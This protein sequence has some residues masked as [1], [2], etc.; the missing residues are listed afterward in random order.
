VKRPAGWYN[1]GWHRTNTGEGEFVQDEETTIAPSQPAQAT[2][3]PRLLLLLVA[4]TVIVGD[5]LSKLLVEQQL[6]LNA[7]WAPFPD[8][9]HLFRI[10]HVSNTGAAL[11]LFPGGSLLFAVVAAA[12]A[13]LILY[14]NFRLPAG[15]HLLRPALGLQLGGALGNLIDRLRIGHVTDFLDFGP[16]PVFNFADAAI[17]AGVVL[18]G[19]MLLRDERETLRARRSEQR[20]HDE[21]APSTLSALQR[22][23]KHEPT[24]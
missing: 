17:V 23:S 8:Y 15:H 16:W 10:T 1:S 13:L 5:Q 20:R 21:Q 9:A 3:W 19:L 6:P 14:Y 4:A 11:G 2:Q 7:S 12:V 18:L 22:P 24:T